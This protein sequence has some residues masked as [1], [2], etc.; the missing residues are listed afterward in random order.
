MDHLLRAILLIEIE[1]LFGV[2]K[3]I[4]HIVC[5]AVV[6][7]APLVNMRRVGLGKINRS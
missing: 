5:R 2:D 1:Q 6:I 7:I 4:D 3:W